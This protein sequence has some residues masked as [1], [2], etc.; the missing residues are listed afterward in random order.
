MKP[1]C[2]KAPP[3][4]AGARGGTVISQQT[5]NVHL[6]HRL[7]CNSTLDRLAMHIKHTALSQ[8]WCP[9]GRCQGLGKDGGTSL[10]AHPARPVKELRAL[11]ALWSW[12]ASPAGQPQASTSPL[13]PVS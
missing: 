11:R 9:A 3:S 2:D 6:R 1:T 13:W 5:G 12:A 7:T 10:R 8:G 4:L